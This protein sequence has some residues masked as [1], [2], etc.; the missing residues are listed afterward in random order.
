MGKLTKASFARAKEALRIVKVTK[1]NIGKIAKKARGIKSRGNPRRSSPRPKTRAT[2][3]RRTTMARRKRR[4]RRRGFTL[5]MAPIAG[6]IPMVIRPIQAL[7]EGN[8]DLAL[9]TF[10]FDTIGYDIPNK[11]WDVARMLSNILPLIAGAAVHKYVGGAP[12]NVNRML[13]QAGVP[14]IRI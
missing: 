12:L 13:A 2:T 1:K 9:K 8:T 3:K 7:M 5:P 14:I 6:M 11:K 10:A 4:S